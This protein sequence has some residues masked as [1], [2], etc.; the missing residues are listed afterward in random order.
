ME[1]VVITAIIVAIGAVLTSFYRNV[2][3]STCCGGEIK[4]RTP[5]P[6]NKS[7]TE[8]LLKK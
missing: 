4:T 8:P 1:P 3:A 2:K 7:I 6:H 5:P